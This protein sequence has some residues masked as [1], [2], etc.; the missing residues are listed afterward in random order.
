M[1]PFAKGL[2]DKI[3]HFALYYKRICNDEYSFVWNLS[4]TIQR[5][6][7]KMNDCFHSKGLHICCFLSMIAYQDNGTLRL[8]RQNVPATSQT[9]SCL[10]Q[11]HL[12][13]AVSCNGKCGLIKFCT[14][15]YQNLLTA[16]RN[17]CFLVVP[18]ASCDS[19]IPHS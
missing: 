8:L 7:S 19:I 1:P 14:V 16:G 6:I 2:C 3:N 9:A 5:I 15:Y 13:P 11:P 4:Q 10:L 17:H 18:K 12:Y